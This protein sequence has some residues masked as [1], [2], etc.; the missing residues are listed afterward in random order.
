M[1]HTTIGRT[2]LD[3]G[4]ARR[5]DLYLTNTQHA[6]QT[7]THEAGGI[8]TRNP[9]KQSAANQPN[10]LTVF[11]YLQRG[12]TDARVSVLNFLISINQ[13]Q[14]HRKEVDLFQSWTCLDIFWPSEFCFRI[15]SCKRMMTKQAS[16]DLMRYSLL[17]DVR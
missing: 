16:T 13:H 10:F 2:P 7:N 14:Q 15:T 12:L 4:S 9:N 17:W 8:R 3:E 5:R 6:Q 1:R 11:I